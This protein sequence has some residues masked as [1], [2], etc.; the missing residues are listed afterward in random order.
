MRFWDFC[1]VESCH[2]PPP[3]PDYATLLPYAKG[4]TK[5]VIP[6][7]PLAQSILDKRDL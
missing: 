3:L 7:G 1:E 5:H 4:F 6:L 2:R